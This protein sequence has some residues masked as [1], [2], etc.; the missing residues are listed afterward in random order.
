M[1]AGKAR[2]AVTNPSRIVDEYCRQDILCK[3]GPHV[4]S[5]DRA[6][7]VRL[8]RELN[9]AM[10]RFIEPASDLLESVASRARGRGARPAPRRVRRS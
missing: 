9:D 5:L 2:R 3:R 7:E 4:R 1:A 8:T 6:T 10:R